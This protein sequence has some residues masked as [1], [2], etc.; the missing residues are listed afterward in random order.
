MSN[1]S[2]NLGNYFKQARSDLEATNESLLVQL[3]HAE[4]ENVRWLIS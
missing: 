3:E 2:K 4:K 1:S